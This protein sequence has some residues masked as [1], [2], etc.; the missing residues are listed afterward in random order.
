[1]P[2]YFADELSI[3]NSINR[4]QP[5]AQPVPEPDTWPMPI[6]GVGIILAI[7]YRKRFSAKG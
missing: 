6:V 5:V 7:R 1:L 4:G 3:I 2:A